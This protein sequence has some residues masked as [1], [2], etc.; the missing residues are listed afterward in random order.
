M[1][2]FDCPH[3]RKPYKVKDALAGKKATCTAC[4][5]PM[6]IPTL[7]SSRPVGGEALESLAGS[8]L[9]DVTPLP[10]PMAA[11]AAIE[12]DC[13]YCFE[14]IEFPPDRAG[15]QAPCPQCRRIIKV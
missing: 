3:C 10:A 15:K 4:K 2:A 14:K 11:P 7:I 5:K 12:L 8:T 13:P 1:I 6:V 9:S